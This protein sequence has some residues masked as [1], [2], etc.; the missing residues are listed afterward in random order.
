MVTPE[1]LIK[2]GLI[3]KEQAKEALEKKKQ[4]PNKSFLDILYELGYISKEE[5]LKILAFDLK[6]PY[7]TE[8]KNV[9]LRDIKVPANILK[10][11]R[12]IPF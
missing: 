8:L 4:N 9:R 11:F 10:Q 2:L 7:V 6:V 3:T 5:Y 12:A 1:Q